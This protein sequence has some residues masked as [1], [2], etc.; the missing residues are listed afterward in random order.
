MR[1]APALTG[2]QTYP[3]VRLAEAKRRRSPRGA[4]P[5]RLRHRRAA[6]GDA[7]LH[8]RGARR[9]RS[10]RS[11]PIPQPTGCPSCARR[12][13]AGSR[14]A[15][16]RALD[17][18]TQVLPTLGSKEAIFHLAQVLGGEPRRGAGAR[19]PGLRARRGCSPAS[20]CS[21]C[22]CARSAA[23]CPTSTR[24][25][26]ATW[27]E[28]A[29]LWLNYPNNPT[30]G[31]RAARALRARGRAR[32]RARL[33]ARLR[34][35]VL[36]DLLRRRAAGLGARA[37]RPERRRGVQHALQALLDARLPLRLRGRRPG[38]DRAA[39]ALPAERRR[40]AAGVHPARR[41]RGLGRRGARRG[42]ARGL[43]RQARR[44]AAACSR[45]TGCAAPAATRPSS[46]GST[47]GPDAD[48]LAERLLEGGIVLAPGSF[49]GPAGARLPAARAR[50]DAR[51]AASAPPSGSTACCGN[52]RATSRRRASPCRAARRTA[53]PRW[54][55]S[56]DSSLRLR[57]SSALSSAPSRMQMFEI[58][59]HSRNTIGPASAP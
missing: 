22:R 42:G 6:R 7:G 47:P 54:A 53:R 51:R 14:G 10:S 11:P 9:R 33:R 34:R 41:G 39:Q 24:S 49:F 40:R 56:P 16:A 19:L 15:S 35:G 50:A 57:S 37:R 59:S 18:D 30:G 38:A 44:A 3:F 25:H 26:A 32:A 28:V 4:G 29:I 20:R 45:R 17:P 48:A 21:S 12:S 2:L 43:P 58:H 23:S 13:P 36:G 1:L 55:T 31:D 8:P 52:R 46:S 27:R 5:D